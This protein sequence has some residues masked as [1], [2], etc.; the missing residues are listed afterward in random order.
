[1][2]I[3]QLEYFVTA[4]KY[5][6][7]TKAAKKLY[8]SQ[9][10]ISLAIKELEQ[11]FETKLFI[12][13]NNV[14][15]LTKE[16]KQLLFLAKPL[17]AHH[18]KVKTEIN[19]FLKKDEVIHIGIPPMVGTLLLPKVS[20]QFSKIHPFAQMEIKEYGSKANQLAV[21]S[22]EIDISITVI[23]NDSKLPTLEYIKIGETSLRL[24][25][26]KNSPLA[27]KTIITFK[28]IE[29]MPLI[30]MNDE[31]LQANIVKE[32]FK[33]NN[34]KPNIRVRSNQI[35]TIKTLLEQNYLAAF[36]FDQIFENDE[37]IVLIPFDKE[38]KFD[39]VV[40]WRK[41]AVLNKISSEF[42]KFASDSLV[43]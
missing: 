18:S 19:E 2:K 43:I 42:I 10:A 26:H 36:A 16:G 28:D 17:L 30:L 1:M 20:K 4:A 11:E 41:E 8:V 7:I 5:N 23:H 14:L 3:S 12:R 35:Y 6:N 29:K 27:N 15:E 32:E 13:N 9:P 31:T 39:I 24:A 34:I 21:E 40:C 22:G 25:V 37:D 33:K 38:F